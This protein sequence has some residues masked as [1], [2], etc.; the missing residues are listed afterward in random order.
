MA[1]I[2]LI[3]GA[4]ISADRYVSISN[5]VDR[6]VRA[7]ETAQQKREAEAEKLRLEKER[8]ELIKARDYKS[9]GALQTDGVPAAWQKWYTQ[10]AVSIKEQNRALVNQRGSINQLDYMD[11]L[12]NQQGAIAQMQNS[13]ATIK[14]YSQAYKEI[15]EGGDF[16]NSLTADEMG[17]IQDI[18]QQNGQ[19]I[20]KDGQ[21]Y[22]K[23]ATTGQEVAFDDLPELT[24]KDYETHNKIEKDIISI[25]ENAAKNGMF[26]G[27]KDAAG[28]S[29]YLQSKVDDYFRNLELQPKQAM[30]LALDFLKM[31]GPYGELAPTFKSL[32]N[33]ELTDIDGDNDIDKDDYI[34][35][36]FQLSEN[37]KIP[38]NFVNRVKE[39]YKSIAMNTSANLKVEYDRVN[40]I[41]AEQERAKNGGFGNKW[42]YDAWLEGQEKRANAVY[43]KP[44]QNFLPTTPVNEQQALELL[45]YANNNIPNIEIYQN[46]ATDDDGELIAPNNYII[47]VNGKQKFFE[48]GKTP[49][50]T[51]FKYIQDLYGYNAMERSTLFGI[52][53]KEE[54]D[55]FAQYEATPGLTAADIEKVLEEERNKDTLNQ[56]EP[57]GAAERARLRIQREQAGLTN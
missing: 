57:T 19:P 55:E 54:E 32:T 35:S 46:P 7:F 44:L 4:G 26:I 56:L 52:D 22:F 34:Q 17:L 11:E 31:G 39:Q 28:D 21:M 27:G 23:S 25:T 12:S 45:S 40:K 1:N 42:E 5:A 41:K 30:S 10:Q 2:A 13:I 38:K 33:Q 16:S 49:G 15:S 18:V 47:E 29:A 20:F 43:I 3:R 36:F 6:G 51:I 53:E 14:E 37:G 48:I 50:S 9:L 8:E 24:T